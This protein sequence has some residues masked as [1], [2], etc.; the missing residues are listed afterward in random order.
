MVGLNASLLWNF[1]CS[2]INVLKR[3]LSGYASCNWFFPWFVCHSELI[4]DMQGV[5]VS[6]GISS[7]R[8]RNGK[9]V[10]V[11]QFLLAALAL[12]VVRSIG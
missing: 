11:S 4:L 7:R 5:G 3:E 12:I 9:R 8:C 1:Y 6:S 2:P 10:R